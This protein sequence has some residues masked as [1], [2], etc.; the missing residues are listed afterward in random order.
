MQ[1]GL[2]FAVLAGLMAAMLSGPARS[3]SGMSKGE[4]II[5][6][7]AGLTGPI[8]L[9]GAQMQIGWQTAVDE[10][11]AAGGING[12]KIRLLIEDDQYEPS[13]AVSAA[14]KLGVQSRSMMVQ[15]YP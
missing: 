12:P 7:Y 10:I 2:G 9:T 13:R 15:T 11:N 3:E 5:S 4:I 6:A 14:R 1:R 8:P